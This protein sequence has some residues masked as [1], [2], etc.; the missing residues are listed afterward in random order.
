MGSGVANGDA[1]KGDL[2][3]RMGQQTPPLNRLD[4]AKPPSIDDWYYLRL[5][6]WVCAVSDS[7]DLMRDQDKVEAYDQLRERT[8]ELGFASVNDALDELE[9]LAVAKR[10]SALG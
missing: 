7:E 8:D 3:A 1:P 9:R 2:H 6:R 5:A 10:M 4:M